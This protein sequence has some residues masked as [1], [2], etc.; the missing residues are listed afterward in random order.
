MPCSVA[1]CRRKEEAGPR[2]NWQNEKK[3]EGRSN[4]H[5]IS[6]QTENTQI[7]PNQ[8]KLS[9]RGEMCGEWLPLLGVLP[10]V[11]YIALWTGMG[12]VSSLATVPWPCASTNHGLR[13]WLEHEMLV[14]RLWAH[15]AFNRQS[16]E[17]SSGYVSK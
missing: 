3:Q 10:H 13:Q 7:T 17:E 9:H 11:P 5:I 2:P 16:Q 12:S 8:E 6:L 15:S 1:T 14:G 4:K